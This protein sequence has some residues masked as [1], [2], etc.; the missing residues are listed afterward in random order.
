MTKEEVLMA[1]E[2]LR[3]QGYT[4]E[5]LLDIYYRMFQD[6]KLNM[7]QLEELVNLLG[8]ELTDEFKKK[9]N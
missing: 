2:E 8:Y 1:N 9:N 4:D 6:G 3:K 5:V 7:D